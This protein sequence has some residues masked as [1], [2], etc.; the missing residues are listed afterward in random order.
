MAD[1]QEKM[2]RRQVERILD[3]TVEEQIDVIVQMESDRP[4]LKNWAKP[5]GSHSL[6]G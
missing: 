5:R 4:R 6:G 2:V 3:E 1:A